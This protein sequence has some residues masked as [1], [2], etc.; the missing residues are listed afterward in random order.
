MISDYATQL[1]STEFIKIG[2]IATYGPEMPSERKDH[3]FVKVDKEKAILIGGYENTVVAN[4]TF[5]YDIGLNQWSYGDVVIQA[6][7]SHVCGLIKGPTYL[8]VLKRGHT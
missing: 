2:Q 1:N 3:C 5:V 6:R 7:F 8:Q 4:T